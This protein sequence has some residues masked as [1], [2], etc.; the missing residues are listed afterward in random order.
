MAHSKP[1]AWLH[2]EIKT[3]PFSLKAR[4]ETGFLLRQIQDGE[5]LGL[6]YSRPMPSIDQTCHELRVRD[7]KQTW[8]VI[9]AL[10]EDAVLILE[11]FA[12]KTAKTPVGVIK[13][14]QRRLR[15]YRSA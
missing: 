15:L 8:R 2:G 11:V 10:E 9:Y 1:L 12:K 4:V 14:C 7:E 6:P 3:P 13:T 5:K